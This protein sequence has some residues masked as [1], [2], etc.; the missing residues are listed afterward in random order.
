MTLV[1]R[2]QRSVLDHLIMI[3]PK[4]KGDLLEAV[5]RLLLNVTDYDQRYATVSFHLHSVVDYL[6]FFFWGGEEKREGIKGDRVSVIIAA[7]DG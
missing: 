5:E 6:A 2:V 7:G 3:Q 1:V 4:F